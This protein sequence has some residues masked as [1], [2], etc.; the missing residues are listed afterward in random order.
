MKFIFWENIISHL[1]TPFYE[2]LLENDAYDVML[3]VDSE[4][5]ASRKKLGWKADTIKGLQVV[6][7][8]SQ[9]EV[10]NI[11]KDNIDAYHF[12]SGINVY[13][14]ASIA[15]GLL[16]KNKVQFS[17]ISEQFKKQ[18]FRGFLKK[19]RSKLYYFKYKN[20]V[21]SIYAIGDDAV[22][23]YIKSGFD[24]SIVHQW[25]YFSK[26]FSIN[27]LHTE[28]NIVLFVGELSDRKNILFLIESFLKL[29]ENNSILKIIGNGMH[30]HKILKYQEEFPNKIQYL[31]TLPTL[32]VREHMAKSKILILPSIFDGWGA[33]VNEALLCGTFCIT[34]DNCGAKTLF[35]SNSS[36]GKTFKLKAK[37]ALT[38]VLQ[39]ELD[40]LD[41]ID[42]DKIKAWAEDKLEIA[43]TVDYFIKTIQHQD[44]EILNKVQA[45]WI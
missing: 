33:V 26:P 17:I 25:I 39:N 11:I 40:N 41:N 22:N 31:G 24:S 9:A 27:R 13:P 5:T 28:K 38:Q 29:K 19:L 16:V 34:S 1:R 21:R 43:K 35:K 20:Y 14:T 45:P 23:W 36:L 10:N 8:P 32:E 2:V 6:I 30:Q 37:N 44:S 12:V 18:G 7:K 4:L 15:L 42:N 3:V